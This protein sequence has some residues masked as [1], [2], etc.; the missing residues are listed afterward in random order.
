VVPIS[1]GAPAW[2]KNFTVLGQFLARKSLTYIT[3]HVEFIAIACCGKHN[4]LESEAIPAS[5]KGGDVHDQG[6]TGGSGGQS[7]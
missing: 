5:E 3:E 1:V 7:Q 4:G 6:R 2:E